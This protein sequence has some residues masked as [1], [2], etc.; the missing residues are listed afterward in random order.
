MIYALA[1]SGLNHADRLVIAHAIQSHDAATIQIFVANGSIFHVMNVPAGA[2]AF[3]IFCCIPV[4]TTDARGPSRLQAVNDWHFEH[5]RE[6]H[7]PGR[8]VGFVRQPPVP[9]ALGVGNPKDHGCYILLGHELDANGNPTN[10]HR[11]R[12]KTIAFGQTYCHLAGA[13]SCS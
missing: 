5:K 4:F 6:G 12:C 9:N 1:N 7:L 11:Q 2:D 8:C 13:N 3:C 10:W